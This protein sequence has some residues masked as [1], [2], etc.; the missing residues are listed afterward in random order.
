LMFLFFPSFLSS[1]EKN[2]LHPS[3]LCLS[4]TE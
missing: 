1:P 3:V 2:H 4:N